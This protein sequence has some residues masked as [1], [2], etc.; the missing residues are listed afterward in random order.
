MMNCV[1][2]ALLPILDAHTGLKAARAHMNCRCLPSLECE[3]LRTVAKAHSPLVRN[4][5]LESALNTNMSLHALRGKKS[6]LV[7]RDRFLESLSLTIEKASVHLKA[8]TFD[9][10]LQCRAQKPLSNFGPPPP[11]DFSSEPPAWPA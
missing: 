3:V 11:F 6:T 5:S 4:Y 8:A 2:R 10:F 9:V 1:C 7:V